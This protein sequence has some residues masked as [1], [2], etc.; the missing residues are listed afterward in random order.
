MSRIRLIEVPSEI[1]A[2]TRGASLG[3]RAMEI[4]A[5][6]QEDRFFHEHESYEV[7][8]E[9]HRSYD[10]VDTPHAIRIEGVLSMYRKVSQAVS[11]TLTAGQ[12]PFVLAG[13][14]STAGATIAG[15][16]QAFPQQ[17]LGVIWIDA[18]ADLHSPYTTPSGNM[19]GMPLAVALG[20]DN[21][22]HKAHKLDE[23]TARAWHE[24][25][26]VGG[27]EPNLNPEDLAFIG[28]RSI[29][30][31][32]EALMKAYD[33]RNFTIEEVRRKGA[34]SIAKACLERLVACDMIYVSFD[35]DSMDDSI[36]RGTGTP[37]PNGLTVAEATGLMESFARD[38]RT[39]C[40]EIVEVNPTLDDKGNVMAETAFGILNRTTQTIEER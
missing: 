25:R 33:I 31:P 5:L 19:H 21:R 9:N 22:G 38:P 30:A 12:Y 39:C 8:A 40:F 7:P 36:S 23:K 16:K 14:H 29:E 11:Q 24:L 27:G 26:Q 3:I 18:H 1:A 6:N 28:V 2:G 10:P 4:A 37:E 17:R 32:E 35:V 20:M 34:E 15:I 13:D